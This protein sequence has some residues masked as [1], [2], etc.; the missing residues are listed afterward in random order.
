MTEEEHEA[1]RSRCDLYEISLM[2]VDHL[3]SDQSCTIE[4]VGSSNLEIVFA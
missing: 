3:C 1:L 2:V 4:I